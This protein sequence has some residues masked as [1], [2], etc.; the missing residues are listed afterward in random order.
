MTTVGYGGGRVSDPSFISSPIKPSL[1]EQKIL[2]FVFSVKYQINFVKVDREGR[3]RYTGE[4][5]KLKI[6][7]G[8]A[9]HEIY[10][11]TGKGSRIIRKALDPYH[12][13]SHEA[14]LKSQNGW[15]F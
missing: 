10:G 5:Y 15:K 1:E 9:N 3:K 13:L 8:S 7:L 2:T 12:F 6:F 14:M 4:S 11:H